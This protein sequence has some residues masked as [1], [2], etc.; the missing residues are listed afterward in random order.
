MPLKSHVFKNYLNSQM[1]YIIIQRFDQDDCHERKISKDKHRIKYTTISNRTIAYSIG[2]DC[3]W[4]IQKTKECS[5][6][7]RIRNTLH[8]SNSQRCIH[9]QNINKTLENGYYRPFGIKDSCFCIIKCKLNCRVSPF[10]KVVGERKNMGQ[11]FLKSECRSC[12]DL[13]KMY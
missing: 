2:Q 11:I 4:C 9:Q 13:L 1:V 7:C 10:Q 12:A 5:L 3:G 8:E 6:I